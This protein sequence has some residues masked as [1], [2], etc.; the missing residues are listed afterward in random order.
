MVTSVKSAAELSTIRDFEHF[1]REAGFSRSKATAIATKGWA[2]GME[3]SDS[4]PDEELRAWLQAQVS[5]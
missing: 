1:L 5:R 4:D 2:A 3:T